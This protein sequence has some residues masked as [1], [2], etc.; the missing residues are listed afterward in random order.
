MADT[1]AE[2]WKT[3]VQ[4]AGGTVSDNQLNA[5]SD[6]IV[7][8]KSDGVWAKLNFI[9]PYYCEIS[10]GPAI[11]LVTRA[12][13]TFTGSPTFAA[14][15]GMTFNGSTQY[16]NT[17]TTGGTAQNSASFFF[18]LQTNKSASDTV[19]MAAG[20]SGD[21]IGFNCAI[22]VKWSD[23]SLYFSLNDD[24]LDGG[25]TGPANTIG[26]YV[27][28]RT[29]AGSATIYKDGSS[30][31]TNSRTSVGTP[32][33]NYHAAAGPNAAGTVMLFSPS[34]LACVGIG[35]G[36]TATDQ[37]NLRTRWNAYKAAL[38]TIEGTA[39]IT[40][41]APALAA[42]GT[43]K[44]QGTASIT[45]P[46]PALSAT[47]TVT[48]QGAASITMPA[49]ALSATGTV[50][51]QGV[52]TITMPAPALAATGG[53]VVQG[54][55]NQTMPA[56]ALSASGA[57]IV[58]GVLSQSLPP[59]A[60][61]ATGTVTAAGAI[62]GV[63]DITMPAPILVATGTVSGGVQEGRARARGGRRR[64]EQDIPQL[65]PAWADRF[66]AEEYDAVARV[67]LLMAA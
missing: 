43:V 30:F 42:T 45:M 21:P 63:A 18:D 19:E 47:G 52:A 25:R 33:Q 31:A 9:W 58:Q 17:G 65:H 57:V 46:V 4:G 38:L 24:N 62:T 29:A 50:L 15:D 7:G 34:K 20:I 36:L 22:S 49:P 11:D 16:S 54:A 40:M 26:F 12:T 64:Q 55:L 13:L 1:D 10:Q 6:M 35:D 39:S 61:V 67:L 56:P 51:V 66:S 37:A 28:S 60:L 48:V 8:L 5:L 3:A 59:P 41:P 27:V 53:V 2:A 23:G 14:R 32:N 44:V